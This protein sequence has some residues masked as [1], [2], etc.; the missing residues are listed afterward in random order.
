M[1]NR[2][3]LFVAAGF[4][5]SLG[6]VV[7]LVAGVTFALFSATSSTQQ[8]SFAAGSVSLSKSAVTDCSVTNMVPGDATAAFSP[9]NSAQTNATMQQCKFTITY[10]GSAPAYLGLDLGVS[11]TAGSAV[12]AYAANNLGTTPSN[13]VGLYDG[14]ANGLQVQISDGTTTYWNGTSVNGSTFGAS[15]SANGLLVNNTPIT[16]GTYTFTVDYALPQGAGNGYQGAGS[17]IKLLVHAVQAG[18]NGTPASIASCVKG[19][20]CAAITSWS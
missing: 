20:T 15:G 13:A 8:N 11:G 4:V 2:K 18:N 7:A 10:T 14:S 3:R 1:Q 16:S 19:Q 9:V 17:N 6:A 5:A 12:Q